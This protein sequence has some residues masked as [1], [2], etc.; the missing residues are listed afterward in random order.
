MVPDPSVLFLID[1]FCLFQWQIQTSGTHGAHS[2]YNTD[3]AAH[4]GSTGKN[5]AV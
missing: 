4:A 1:Y 5:M 2:I 3:F